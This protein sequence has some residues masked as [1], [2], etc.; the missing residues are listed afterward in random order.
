MTRY[1]PSFGEWPEA[2]KTS[3][4]DFFGEVD[5]SNP[6]EAQRVSRFRAAAENS[7][8]AGRT[9]AGLASREGKF[10]RDGRRL[11][12]R[13]QARTEA[14]RIDIHL[15]FKLLVCSAPVACRVRGGVKVVQ[16][17]EAA[18]RLWAKSLTDCG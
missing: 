1:W 12:T 6:S 3:T 4:C 13:C 2:Q 7:E 9:F 11:G 10:R 5:G 15:N 8:R 14:L 16:S 17:A 18:L